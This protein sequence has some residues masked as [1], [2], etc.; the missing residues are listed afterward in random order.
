MNKSKAGLALG[1][2][3]AVGAIASWQAPAGEAAKHDYWPGREKVIPHVSGDR[4]FSGTYDNWKDEASIRA[5]KA[6]GLMSHEMNFKDFRWLEK[7]FDAWPVLEEGKEYFNQPNAAGKS[8]ASCH[9][10]DGEKLKGVYANLP[11]FNARL[12]KVVVGPTQIRA[13]AKDYLGIDG[14]KENTRPNSVLDMYVAH[15]SDGRKVDVD[16]ISPGPLKEAYERGKNLY[17]KRTGQF[18]FACAS[19]HTPPT[20]GNYLRGQRPSTFFGD[21]AHYPIYHFPYTLP[22]DDLAHVFT[23]QHQIRSCQMLSRMSQGTEGSRSMVDIEVFLKA[24]ANGYPMSIPTQEYN[25]STDY[26]KR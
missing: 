3:A 7:S 9:G 10:P 25:M 17:F 18:H 5:A 20:V 2:V 12:G 15:L 21:A 4:R 22:G 23:L 1:A 8:C 16:V 19:C 14:W 6:K 13:C 26:L 11:R 24:S